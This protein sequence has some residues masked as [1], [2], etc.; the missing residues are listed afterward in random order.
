MGLNDEREKFRQAQEWLRSCEPDTQQY[1]AAWEHLIHLLGSSEDPALLTDA[2]NFAVDLLG[3][4]CPLCG[5]IVVLH[6][7]R[8]GGCLNTLPYDENG[9]VIT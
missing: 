4:S 1:K 5:Q 3:R 2:W 9:N 6:L 7:G 8:G